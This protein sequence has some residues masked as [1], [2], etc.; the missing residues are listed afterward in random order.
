M[1]D[2]AQ[3]SKLV[4]DHSP[5]APKAKVAIESLKRA[6]LAEKITAD[7]D[8]PPFD[9]VALD[10]IAIHYSQLEQLTSQGLKLLGCQQAGEA[11]KTFDLAQGCLEA[12]TGAPLPQHADT[13]I[14]YEHLDIKE[15]KVFLKT[16]I[17]VR[18]GQNIHNTGAD[19]SKGSPLISAGQD[20]DPIAWSIMA[21]VGKGDCEVYKKPRVAIVATGDEIVDVREQPEPYQ[22]RMSNTW[23]L[24]AM[25]QGFNFEDTEVFHIAD[26]QHQLLR[27]LEQ[28]LSRFDVLI[29][30]GGVSMGKFDYIPKVLGDLQVEKIFHRVAQKPGK[31]LWFGVSPSKQR[32]FGLPGNPVSALICCRRYVVPSLLFSEKQNDKPIFVKLGQD[33]NFHKSLSYFKPVKL[34]NNDQGMFIAF[35]IASNGSGD[36]ASLLG[37]DGFLEL[38]Q[39]RQFFKKAEVY[40]YFSWFAR[41]L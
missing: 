7:R 13:V 10:G 23:A 21:S 19:Y 32:V 6:V 28:I 30:S 18:S 5:V 36:F 37:S 8:Y 11:A 9:R 34:M 17:K 39:D 4:L 35:P 40:P 1:I 31:P 2:V 14:P 3:A 25:L 22:I 24:K 27:K 20:L 33:L 16:H 29:L 41:R 15:E 38:P 26:D 12:M